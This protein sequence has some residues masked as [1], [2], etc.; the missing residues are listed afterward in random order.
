MYCRHLCQ[1]SLKNN[2]FS[3][4]CECRHAP[5]QK[6]FKFKS[7]LKERLRCIIKQWSSQKRKRRE[8]T[9]KSTASSAPL[10][11]TGSDVFAV[12]QPRE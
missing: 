7:L 10:P 4:T 8:R 5:R 11:G 6:K 12:F 3:N 1:G 2:K 9:C